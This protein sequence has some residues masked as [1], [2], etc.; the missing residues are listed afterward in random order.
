M[1]LTSVAD[2]ETPIRKLRA[3]LPPNF[4]WR[5]VASRPDALPD[6][7]LC[8]NVEVLRLGQH[9]NDRVLWVWVD[10]HL[11]SDRLKG[12][13]CT[14]YEQGVIGSELW[15]IRHQDRLRL[16]VQQQRRLREALRLNRA[17]VTPN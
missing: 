17:G 16:E 5:S 4:R 14:S 9:V 2:S 3:M 12:R 7:L 10:R 11:P 13:A 1:A 15:A 6:A 8:D